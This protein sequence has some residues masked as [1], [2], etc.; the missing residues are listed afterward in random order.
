MK[1]SII[2]VSYNS[3]ATLEQ[4]WHG[5]RA[6]RELEW[7]VVDN[8]S[9][10]E[11]REVAEGLGA[12]VIPLGRNIGFGG[13][14]NVGLANSEGEHIVFVNPDV[15]VRVEDLDV[16]AEYLYAN[17][18]HLVAP[19]LVNADGSMQPNGRGLPYLGNKVM[20]RL[21]PGLLEGT[22]LRLAGPDDVVVCEWLMGA[23]VAG[24]RTHLVNLGPWDTRFFVYYEDSDLGLRNQRHGGS[25]VVL[26]SLRWLHGW[27]RET[28]RPSLPAWRRE[29]PSLLKFYS[30]YP[31]LLGVPDL[32]KR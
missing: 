24:T 16:I 13:A 17:P 20:N 4:F 5:F 21:R 29:I 12:K 10:D 7:I 26:G 19:Q 30:R 22:Y 6:N 9:S 18:T 3:A 11:S 25:S 15:R 14:N 27:A 2:T 8:D 31:R 28:K 32:W 1:W 23:V